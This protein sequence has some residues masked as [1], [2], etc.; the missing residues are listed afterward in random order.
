MV[1]LWSPGQFN[2]PQKCYEFKPNTELLKTCV[3]AMKLT[4]FS[5]LYL[6]KLLSVLFLDF[7]LPKKWITQASNLEI[8]KKIMATLY[9]S[10]D[11][12]PITLPCSLAPWGK[13]R[14]TGLVHKKKSGVCQHP[15]KVLLGPYLVPT[16][17]I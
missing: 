6:M 5:L 13:Y 8:T 15:C 7:C 9:I 3:N 11:T 16:L 1:L 2:G 12:N 14:S 10:M 17:P 4:H